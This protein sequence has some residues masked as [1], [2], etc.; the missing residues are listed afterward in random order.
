MLKSLLNQ[1]L[2]VKHLYFYIAFY[3]ITY[4]PILFY[5]I[6]GDH[7]T[8]AYIGNK[9]LNGEKLYT[10]LF[11]SNFPTLYMLN[12][13]FLNIGESIWVARFLLIIFSIASVIAFYKLA[14]MSVI[15]LKLDEH[16]SSNYIIISLTSFIFLF[17]LSFIYGSGNSGDTMGFKF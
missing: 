5:P 12:G 17:N 6:D 10:Q 4:L 3:V 15:Y 7:W 9:F 2:N 1:I 11:D 8:F 16:Q 14:K 13:L